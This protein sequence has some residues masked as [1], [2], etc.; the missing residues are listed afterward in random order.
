M[1]TSNISK[2]QNLSRREVL[3]TGALAGTTAA[4][5]TQVFGNNSPETGSKPKN[6]HI[7]LAAYSMRAALQDGSMDL[8]GFIDWCAEM[9]LA[10]TELTSYYFTGTNKKYLHKLKHHAFK[11]GV[12]I[13]GTA[14]RNNFCLPPGPEKQKEIDHVRKW[15]DYSVEF[16]APHIRIFAG[17]IPKDVDKQTC[18]GWA[19]DGIR[20]VLDHA[21]DRGIMIGLENHGGI[22][23]RAADHL[24][25]CDAVGDHPWFGINLDTGNY[26]TNAYEEL[27]V[28]APRAVNVQLKVEVFKND[29]SKVQAD[30]ERL[31]SIL[32]KAGYKGWIALEYEAEED[33]RIAIP[34]Y[35]KK[36]KDMFEV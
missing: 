11:K 1:S 29:G 28:A 32:V 2:R 10:G 4:F 20:E 16:F 22:T 5:S 17:S 19:A 6:M 31:K 12:T 8:F 33:P 15:I 27:A 24:A 14:V 25:I 36:L 7:S 3:K 21:A 23:A 26:R 13:S 30:F 35:V 34:G 9:D 18:I